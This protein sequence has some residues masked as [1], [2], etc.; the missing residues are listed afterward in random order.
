M[1]PE[2]IQKGI[3]SFLH[4]NSS[5]ASNRLVKNKNPLSANYN[6]LVPARYLT[7]NRTELFKKSQLFLNMLTCQMS[8]KSHTGDMLL[9]IS[10]KSIFF[11][12]TNFIDQINRSL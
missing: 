4:E 11:I 3:E 5:I 6:S 10:K 2:H 12:N 7:E 9:F 1:L 8:L